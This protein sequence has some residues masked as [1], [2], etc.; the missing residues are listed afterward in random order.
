MGDP[1]KT[2][3][4]T[5]TEQT[6][7]SPETLGYYS[8]QLCPRETVERIDAGRGNLSRKFLSKL[9]KT[10]DG[11]ARKRWGVSIVNETPRRY[12]TY[13]SDVEEVILR[14]IRVI[15]I[16]TFDE[17]DDFL[18]STI[19]YRNGTIRKIILTTRSSQGE[20]RRAFHVT[21]YAAGGDQTQ[22]NDGR[23]QSRNEVVLAFP[24]SDDGSLKDEEQ[25]VYSLLPTKNKGFK[26]LIHGNFAVA[27]S[28]TRI[29][30]ASLSETNRSLL[31][32]IAGAIVEAAWEFRKDPKLQ[33]TWV[34]S[35]P[36]E[37]RQNSP[38]C[39]LFEAIKARIATEKVWST[40][41]AERFESLDSLCPFPHD[42]TDANEQPLFSSKDSK[43][44]YISRDYSGSCVSKLHLFGLANFTRDDKLNLIES[45]LANTTTGSCWKNNSK[46]REWYLRVSRELSS[47][48][49][50]R[51]NGD[52]NRSRLERLQIIPLTNGAWITPLDARK[53]AAVFPACENQVQIPANLGLSIV[54][55]RF[56]GS[57]GA[58]G[59]AELNIFQHLGVKL[60]ETV[61]IRRRIFG[62]PP[63]LFMTYEPF[64][65]YVNCLKYLYLTDHLKDAG[66]SPE[67]F[68][69]LVIYDQRIKAR[70]PRKGDKVFLKTDDPYGASALM[71]VPTSEHLD[72]FVPSFIHQD[73]PDFGP[74]K[75][76][77]T[78]PPWRDWLQ[79]NLGLLSTPSLVTPGEPS[80][81]SDEFRRINEHRPQMFLDAVRYYWKGG[82]DVG[83]LRQ[84]ILET[85]VKCMG[86]K[87]LP[88]KDTFLP[89]KDLERI[90]ASFNA[91][92]TSSLP[93]LKVDTRIDSGTLWDFLKREFGVSD[94]ANLGF[95]VSLLET[96]RSR[97]SH[98]RPTDNESHLIRTLYVTMQK[99]CA[100]PEGQASNLQLIRHCFRN[101]PLIYYGY[102]WYTANQCLWY[103]A[104]QGGER[105]GLRKVYKILRRFFQETI[106]VHTP[107]LEDAYDALLRKGN[108]DS[109]LS[110]DEIV[111][112]I[113]ELNSLLRDSASKLTEEQRGKLRKSKIFPVR[114]GANVSV[115]LETAEADFTIEDDEDLGKAFSEKANRL[116]FTPD[117][118]T[119][120]R[121]ILGELG[122]TGR[123]ISRLVTGRTACH[124]AQG[125]RLEDTEDRGFSLRARSMV[126][127]AIHYQSLRSDCPDEL[128]KTLQNARL[129]LADKVTVE[130]RLGPN[131]KPFSPPNQKSEAHI[132]GE[133]L[134]KIW[135]PSDGYDRACCFCWKL[136]ERLLKW[137]MS[138]PECNSMTPTSFERALGVMTSALNAP[139]HKLSRIL[140]EEN[141][142]SWGEDEN[143]RPHDRRS[144]YRNALECAI[145]AARGK[146]LTGRAMRELFAFELLL[147]LNLPGFGW[148]SWTS[149]HRCR[150]AA[151]P[152]YH[153][154][155][156][157]REGRADII[158][159][160][161]AGS[162]TKYLV[163]TG[164]LNS[165]CRNRKPTYLIET[166]ATTSDKEDFRFSMSATQE[167]LMKG[168]N[169]EYHEEYPNGMVYVLIRIWGAM[170]VNIPASLHIN[171]EGKG[172]PPTIEKLK[173]HEFCSK[174]G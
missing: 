6:Q 121:N 123:Y 36:T 172:M 64:L 170:G 144:N 10:C 61:D 42:W 22:R 155:P 28:G 9:D 142:M 12:K 49:D 103:D 131:G 73:F 169:I 130:L 134:L 116:N 112:S 15:S 86:K 93:V 166:K 90:W 108:A 43:T 156:R 148:H 45:D 164:K 2:M 171:P 115:S 137:L 129:L 13:R 60:A 1:A 105:V 85:E 95:Y 63:P 92:D 18:N 34:E 94:Q 37:D 31:D 48:L 21:Q 56:A 119:K 16:N 35:L 14:N 153:D 17:Q 82:D 96:L 104:Y 132:E 160:D 83:A 120:L 135:V 26:F 72:G 154:I 167:T 87:R 141:I 165:S 59:V 159:H 100:E 114:Q 161:T 11:A 5:R 30:C 138:E 133:D 65:E 27:E 47:L 147:K 67:A 75:Q 62:R 128:Y 109:S 44:T 70:Q 41:D 3:I 127:I 58:E 40:Y 113:W 136:P 140:D 146:D 29:L 24:L 55:P 162:F 126:R 81:L 38:L 150:V 68:E 91:G 4:R 151:H 71:G 101:S 125:N 23:S 69:N 78:L 88:L 33:H 107:T 57:S 152:D 89:S 110:E 98:G 117:G 76:I 111:E 173:D 50:D 32:A 97:L 66:E 54:E 139:P 99:L 124:I 79:S 46:S 53:W 158:L 149:K 39:G 51:D 122:L 77:G 74:E 106:Q 52:E 25:K 102:R 8:A 84:Q 168:S 80:L 19:F 157:A 20:K 7:Q 145:T 174:R 163:E 143:C 118:I